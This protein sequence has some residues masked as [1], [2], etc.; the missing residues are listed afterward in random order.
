VILQG[1][2]LE[3]ERRVES[4]ALSRIAEGPRVSSVDGKR[5]PSVLISVRAGKE[6]WPMVDRVSSC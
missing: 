3:E 1:E 5:V 6:S 4:T 2:D